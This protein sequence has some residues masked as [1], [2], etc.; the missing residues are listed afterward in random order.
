MEY[1]N[2]NSRL[3]KINTDSKKVENLNY[4]GE[5]TIYSGM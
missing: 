4:W 3:N 1:A 5:K 2:E